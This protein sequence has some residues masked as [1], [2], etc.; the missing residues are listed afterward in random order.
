MKK[1][2][3]IGLRRTHIDYLKEQFKD[4]YAISAL[5]DQSKHSKKI[6]NS[7]AYQTIINCT[8][9]TNHSTERLYNKHSGF[10]RISGGRSSVKNY[11]EN[12]DKTSH[13][14]C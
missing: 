2:L 7:E 6:S 9:F 14:Y 12:I 5:D 3:V 4:M 8:K 13:H 10:I 1:V 11:L